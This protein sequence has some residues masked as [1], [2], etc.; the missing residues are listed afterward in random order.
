M[1]IREEFSGEHDIN[2]PTP[3][4]RGPVLMGVVLMGLVLTELGGCA[5]SVDSQKVGQALV[6]VNSA[7]VTSSQ[8]NF[9]VRNS[10]DSHQ[11]PE[12]IHNA[13]Q[14]LVDQELV[15]QEAIKAKLDVDPDV[16]QMLEASR[17]QILADAYA[18]RLIYPKTPV[19]E[20]KQKAYYHLHPELFEK[21]RWYGLQVF[22]IPRSALDPT[23][24]EALDTI[25]SEEGIRIILRARKIEFSERPTE[26]S[27][28]QLPFSIVKQFADAK[29]GDILVLPNQQL[30]QLMQIVEV[31]ERPV[32]FEDA[33]VMIE[34][35]LV[36]AR[37]REA[38]Q[39]HIKLLRSFAQITYGEEANREGFTKISEVAGPAPA[40]LVTANTDTS[41]STSK[42]DGAEKPH[43]IR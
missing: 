18:Q 23:L 35:Y 15:V 29:V 17:R 42:S 41:T 3:F 21:R 19:P 39:S 38:M 43:M 6:K 11:S 20:S 31:E 25:K 40:S 24:L 33:Q 34:N 5:K 22:T 26:Q 16:V 2:L 36:S 12:M 30:A 32:T 28:E 1:P 13:L 4:S 27:S 8:L 9:L 10:G 14:T 37:N 7:D